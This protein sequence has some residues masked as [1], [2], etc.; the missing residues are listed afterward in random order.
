VLDVAAPQDKPL[1]R[2]ANGTDP[3]ASVARTK[4]ASFD[5]RPFLPHLPVFEGFDQAEI[6]EVLSV[7]SILELPRGQKVF[8]AGQPST[9]CFIVVRGAVKIRA[10]HEKRER[11]MAVLGPGQ[12]L[13]YMSAIEKSVHGSDAVVREQALLLEISREAFEQL[14]FSASPAS[15]KLHRAIQK[16]L[17]SS[18]GQTNR[19]LTRLISQARLRGADQEGNAL[20]VAR[21]GQIMA[22]L[23]G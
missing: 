1:S 4:K 8:A 14:Y 9:A 18:L 15:T 6:E 2:R 7:S 13:G 19:H 5:F 20:E 17:L 3:L 12:L 23:G 16:S 22:A 21:S 11:R 10:Q